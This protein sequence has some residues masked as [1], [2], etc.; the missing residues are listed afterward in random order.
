MKKEKHV[1]IGMIEVGYGHRGP[2]LVLQ[3]ALIDRYGSQVSVAVLDMVQ[4][5]GAIQDDRRIKGAWDFSIQYPVMVRFSYSAMEA[6]YP[7]V[8]VLLRCAMPHFFSRTLEYLRGQQP[9][10]VVATHP[11]VLRAVVW[12]RKK[13]AFAFPVVALVVDPLNAYALWADPETDLFVVHSEWARD[14]LLHRG[15]VPGRICLVPY[16]LLPAMKASEMGRDELRSLYGV[17]DENKPVVLVTSGA[18]GLG[19]VYGFVERA[20]EENCPLDFLVVTGKNQSLFQRMKALATHPRRGRLVPLGQVSRMEELYTLCDVVAGKAG[21]ATCME[22][23][24]HGR[25][26]L[27]TEWVAQNDYRLLTFLSKEELGFYAPRYRSFVRFLHEE[28]WRSCKKSSLVFS[29]SGILDVLA[30]LVEEGW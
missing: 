13:G 9:D 27:C 23:L 18:Q 19:R 21:A 24:Y 22:A 11:M 20:Y 6:L 3:K 1:L 5:V 10:L 2:A 25:P 12:A 17:G 28:R 26:F 8:S 14:D 7:A 15:I 29:N 4:A 30:S 16:P